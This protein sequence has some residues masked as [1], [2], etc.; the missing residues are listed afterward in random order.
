[1]AF[2]YDLATTIGTTR[3]LI[4][5][6][7]DA[8]H[9]FEDAELTAFLTLNGDDPRMAAADALDVIGSSQVM[10]LKYI[11]VNDLTTNGPA[12]GKELRDR[13]TALRG[14]AAAAAM[15]LIVSQAVDDFTAWNLILR[16]LIP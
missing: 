9:V 3:L 7:T 11:T 14:Q 15:P 2:T 10:I 13:A 6:A 1:M 8:G 16:E 12:V 4:P 5:D